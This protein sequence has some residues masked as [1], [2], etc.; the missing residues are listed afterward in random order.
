M[1][2]S[3]WS[4]RH[5]CAA[6]CYTTRMTLPRFRRVVTGHDQDG[7]AVFLS[8]GA[9]PHMFATPEGVGVADLLWLNGPPRTADDGEDLEGAFDLEPPPG[10]CSVRIL[11]FPPPPADAPEANRWIRVAGEDPDRPGMHATDTLDFMAVL[12]GEIVLDLDDGEHHLNQGD[13]VIQRGNVHRWRVA[14][15]RPCTYAVVMIR[16]DPASDDPQAM[17]PPT[18]GAAGSWRRLVAGTDSNGRSA[19]LV[20][21]PAAV[22]YEPAGPGGVSLVELWQT[23][24]LPQNPG[25]GGDPPGSWQLEPRHRGIAFRA[26]EMPAGLDSGEAGWHTTDTIDV[27]IMISGRLEL[28]LPNVEPVVLGPGDAVVQR[29]THHK[30][31]PVG[32]EPVRYVAVMIALRP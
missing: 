19:A 3:R 10:G 17:A 23:G 29:G 4:P 20:D 6:G 16:P 28:A 14:G 9:P 27:D 30:W 8:D 5:V 22:V 18:A 26:I 15:E 7:S 2:P 13:C 1:T 12:D 31:T 24:G 21:G 32:D 25:V 11:C